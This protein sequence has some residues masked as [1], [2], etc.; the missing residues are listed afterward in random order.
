VRF[1]YAAWLVLIVA[2]AVLTALHLSAD[3]PNYSPWTFDWA[4]YT[5]EGWYGNAAIRAHI[6]GNW[7]VPGDF[8]PAVAL[9]VLPFIEWLLFSVT[10]V[11]A[12][13]ARSLD[14]AFFFLSLVLS[15]MLV[16]DKGERWAG[17]MAVTLMVTSPF[18]YSFSR[19]AI[20]EPILIALTLL[21]LNIAV[22]LPRMR[23]RALLSALLGIL[24]AV[25]M[26]TKTTAFFLIPAPLWALA[27]SLRQERKPMARYLAIAV[28]TAMAAYALWM[29]IV[30]Q[31]GLLAD[32]RYLFFVNAYPK[33]RELYWPLVAA[34]WSFH[35]EL[36]A[37]HVLMP[38]AVLVGVAAALAWILRGRGLMADPLFGASIAAATG[39]VLFMTFQNH[40]QPRYFT[41]VAVFSFIQLTRGVE[42]LVSRT[43]RG[44][45][46]HPKFER[47]VGWAV[48]VATIAAV[49][50]NSI[51]TVQYALHPSYTFVNAARQLTEYI[52]SHPNGNRQ[53]LSISGDEIS[54]ITHLP[55]LCDDFGTDP[56]ETKAA[57][58]RPG[59]FAAWNSLDPG[60]LADLHTHFSLEQVATFRAFDDP[61]RNQMY[62]FKLHPLPRNRVRDQGDVDLTR[63]LADDKFDMPID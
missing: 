4:K 38:L 35:G 44:L 55:A 9:P 40:P 36:W 47:V 3:F 30:W 11:S 56:L 59:W 29:T 13:A 27:V 54:L 45:Y 62:L 43:A 63:Q 20:L 22:R 57:Q 52:D 60:A 53:L 39:Y 31:C 37:D 49:G 21:T 24:F 23:R 10:G 34:F 2:F 32:Y 46:T 61:E 17:L 18:L 48:L 19:L 26:L 16:R 51:R 28:G 58:Y 7:Y 33:P 25:M 6:T 1:G 14:V 41:V 50:V 5:D 12:Q 8:N 42:V 15:Y